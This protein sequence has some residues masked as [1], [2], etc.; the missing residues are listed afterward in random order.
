MNHVMLFAMHHVH[1]FV[2]FKLGQHGAPRKC[3]WLLTRLAPVKKSMNAVI[4][5]ACA[6]NVDI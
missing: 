6:K 1:R 3:Y 5:V 4:V 2:N